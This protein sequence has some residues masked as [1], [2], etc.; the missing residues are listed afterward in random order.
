M[1]PN[2]LNAQETRVAVGH[3]GERVLRIIQP[4]DRVVLL[5]ERGRELT[6][7]GLAELLAWAGDQGCPCLVF[8]IGGPFGHSPAVRARAN[9]SIRL[10]PMVLNHAVAKVGEIFGK[11]NM[12]DNLL[13]HC[14]HRNVEFKSVAFFH[15]LQ[16]VLLEQLYRAWTILR[17][18]PYHH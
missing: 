8:V 7:E 9:D 18:E 15:S 5:D 3:E 14:R 12:K 16:V 11:I 2:P 10:S 6:S 1:K 13:Q 17:G 4:S